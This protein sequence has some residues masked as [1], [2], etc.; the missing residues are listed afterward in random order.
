MTQK[1]GVS[2]EDAQLIQ[3]ALHKLVQSPDFSHSTFLNL[4][5]KNIVKLSEDFDESVLNFYYSQEDVE[6]KPLEYPN[7]ELV[8]V[9]IYCSDGN[10]LT[11]WERVILNLPKQYISRPIYV[12]EQDAQKAAKAKPLFINE[13]YVAVFVDK[14]SIFEQDSDAFALQD[15]FGFELLNLKD[16]A[17]DLSKIYFFWHN[18]KQYLFKNQSLIFSKDVP[19][20]IQEA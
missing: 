2:L 19:D 10:N 11:A 13:G 18:S 12:R 1:S 17:I 3:E 4:I 7:H 5:H 16:R 6:V 8:Y 9:S 14:K 15:K 20:F